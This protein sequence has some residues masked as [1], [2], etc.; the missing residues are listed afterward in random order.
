MGNPTTGEGVIETN[1]NVTFVDN[2]NNLWIY[3]NTFYRAAT[4]FINFNAVNS[5]VPPKHYHD[6][7]WIEQNLFHGQLLDITANDG[8]SGAVQAEPTNQ[9]YARSVARLRVRN[10]TFTS[11]H[12]EYSAILV[13]NLATYE[14]NDD[15]YITD[16]CFSVDDNGSYTG[17]GVLLIDCVTNV[18][19][20][21]S[22]KS[23]LQST[24][25]RV[26]DSGTFTINPRVKVENNVSING[27]PV[28]VTLP[29]SYNINLQ[30]EEHKQVSSLVATSSITS[31]DINLE[32]SGTA[33]LVVG[34]S[35]ITIDYTDLGLQDLPS[36]V[37][38]IALSSNYEHPIYWRDKSVTGFTLNR[39]DTT[40]SQQVDWAVII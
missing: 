29:S 35:Q 16:N 17:T 25:I 37:Y 12:G 24:D 40:D 26:S 9:L 36:A 22:C 13:A 4:P 20:N 21:N 1:I 30:T 3:K 14:E 32:R 5:S 38:A 34:V 28:A 8:S 39:L 15:V 31:P 11:F 27:N 18:I 19:T 7:I 33:V 2:V 10:N 6:S 23:G